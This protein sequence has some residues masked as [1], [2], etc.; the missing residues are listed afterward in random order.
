LSDKRITLSSDS[1]IHEKLSYIL[2]PAL[3]LVDAVFAFAGFIE[4]AAYCYL[5]VFKRYNSRFVVKNQPDFSVAQGQ[6][7]FGSG[8]DYIIHLAPP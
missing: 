1:R 6:P 3:P 8:K 4:L 7:L 2:E 5:L